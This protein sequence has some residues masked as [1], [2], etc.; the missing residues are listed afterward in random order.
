L[1]RIAVARLIADP[2]PPTNFIPLEQLPYVFTH[3]YKPFHDLKLVVSN[4]AFEEQ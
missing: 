3:G 2:T 1:T 4:R